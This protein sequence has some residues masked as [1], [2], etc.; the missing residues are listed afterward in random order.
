[1]KFSPANQ[2]LEPL[3]AK[4]LTRLHR[5]VLAEI[6]ELRKHLLS[7]QKRL[8]PVEEAADYLGVSPKTIRNRLG[9]KASKPFP[10]KPVRHGGK[11][12]FR[13]DDLDAYIDHLAAEGS[14]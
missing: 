9:P 2:T 8:L 6:R 3:D 10:V 13:R 14:K 5:E 4:A 12:L 7:P 1:M 11:V